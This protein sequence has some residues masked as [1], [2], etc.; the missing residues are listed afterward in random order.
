MSI[1]KRVFGSDIPLEVKK[2]LQARQLVSDKTIKPNESVK[3]DADPENPTTLNELVRNEFGGEADLASRTAFVRM[4]TAVELIEVVENEGD[5]A[6]EEDFVIV[7]RSETSLTVEE[8]F[9]KQSL[10]T[11]KDLSSK[12]GAQG[13]S[14]YSGVTTDSDGGGAT[15]EGEFNNFVKSQQYRNLKKHYPTSQVVT[16][17]NSD[18]RVEFVLVQ[19]G[20]QTIS[21][22]KIYEI[23]NHLINTT[24]RITPNSFV[25]NETANNQAAPGSGINTATMTQREIDLSQDLFPDEHA[26]PNDSN[27]FLKPASGIVSVDQ[28]TEGALGVIKVTTVNFVVHNN[29]DYNEI[30]SK[31]FLKPGAQVFVD[32]G[33]N[34]VDLYDPRDFIKDNKLNNIEKHIWGQKYIEGEDGWVTLNQ[35]DAESIAGIVSKYDAKLTANGSWECS[36]TITSKNI[37]LFDF[38]KS[39]NLNKKISFLLDHFIQFRALYEMGDASDRKQFPE[40]QSQGIGL[41]KMQQRF[42]DEDFS[43]EDIM[44]WEKWL[45]KFAMHT[46]GGDDMNPGIPSILAGIFMPGDDSKSDAKY[47]TWGYLEDEILNPMFGFGKDE[48]A[49]TVKNPS[50]LQIVIDSTQQ[51]TTYYSEYRQKQ[52]VIQASKEKSPV[53][54]IPHFWDRSY[55]VDR[56]RSPNLSQHYGVPPEGETEGS[57][58]DVMTEPVYEAQNF[59]IQTNGNTDM[60][61]LPQTYWKDLG[62]ITHQKIDEFNKQFDEWIGGKFTYAPEWQWQTLRTSFD[63]AKKRIPLREIFI[64]TKVVID[65][66]QNE[67]SFR[68]IVKNIL[69]KV[70]EDSYGIFDWKLASDGRDESLA[71]IDSN[72][73]T[74]GVATD[75]EQD[76][77]DNL[78]KFSVMGSNSIVTNYNLALDTP[79]DTISSVYAIQALSGGDSQILTVDGD[80]NDIVNLQSIFKLSKSDVEDPN[81]SKSDI[82]IKYLPD[83]G[84]FRAKKME[85]NTLGEL[86][87]YSQYYTEFIDDFE[88]KSKTN[89]SYGFLVDNPKKFLASHLDPKGTFADTPE[90]QAEREQLRQEIIERNDKVLTQSGY[91]VLNSFN[92]YFQYIIIGQ[93]NKERK[94]SILPLSLTITTYGISNIQPGDIFRVDFLPEIYVD[95]IFFQVIKVKHKIASNGWYTEL[96]T[97]FRY[98]PNVIQSVNKRDARKFYLSTNVLDGLQIDDTKGHKGIDD[99]TQKYKNFTFNLD[100]S[101]GNVHGGADEI[102]GITGNNDHLTSTATGYGSPGQIYEEFV[103][104]LAMKLKVERTYTQIWCNF[105]SRTT[106][107]IPK[108]KI[109]VDVSGNPLST[110]HSYRQPNKGK[111][112]KVISSLK[113]LYPYMTRI[114]PVSIQKFKYRNIQAIFRFQ[115]TCPEQPIVWTNLQYYANTGDWFWGGSD[116]HYGYAS[117]HGTGMKVGF[118][119]DGEFGYLI[120]NRQDPSRFWCIAPAGVPTISHETKRFRDHYDVHPAKTKSKGGFLLG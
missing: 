13:A 35:G 118:F 14:A 11:A 108:M 68:K 98:R 18:G 21:V 9:L 84:S 95:V 40:L 75:N 48:A 73:L 3:L 29:A 90:A 2:K 94:N 82:K 22:P 87:S 47:I 107:T 19:K 77:F 56:D 41:G 72:H 104:A 76:Y 52:E 86:Q 46:F 43:A 103:H 54:I 78:F 24:D 61:L 1:H 60:M 111:T 100:Y 65:A 64:Q 92:E 17:T 109:V 93:F 88:T 6:E 39:S 12:T 71:I 36:V 89:I 49:L 34:N 66:F 5:F 25:A 99:D 80:V 105:E 4:W 32:F 70:N 117:K 55:G 62:G 112:F 69:D 27:K 59:F 113:A 120:I 110:T 8:S 96:E 38:T 7:G 44:A 81:S 57:E 23:N 30:F 53:F 37:A 83:V 116:T 58:R 79:S 115:F 85:Q 42:P 31:Y 67:T 10:R 15:V 101:G 97:Q 114:E 45:D 119:Q 28:S 16:R 102:Y 106:Y 50:G 26:V 33:W 74:E 63:K 51:F 91:I 20:T